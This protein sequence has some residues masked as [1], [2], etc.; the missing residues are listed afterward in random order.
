MDTRKRIFEEA[1]RLFSEKGYSETTTRELSNAVGIQR[2]SLY[3]HY[4]SKNL[5]LYEICITSLEDISAAVVS[6]RDTALQARETSV[7]VLRV[8]VNAHMESALLHQERHATMLIELRHLSGDRRDNVLAARRGYE[9]LF[10]NQIAAAQDGGFLRTDVTDRLLSLA[11]L[12]LLNWTIFWF[13]A[14]GPASVTRLADVFTSIF[15]TGVLR[16]NKEAG[17]LLPALAATT[18]G[19]T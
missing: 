9:T 15:L 7:E 4:A 18:E 12:N 13:S 16:C 19:R 10:S 3:H 11:L 2:A 14:G 5:I 1:A 8:M 17:H 6:A